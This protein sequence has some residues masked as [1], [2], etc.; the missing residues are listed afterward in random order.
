M[1]EVFVFSIVVVFEFSA[2]I[3]VMYDLTLRI[4]KHSFI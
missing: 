4:C 1:Y 3:G 2:L